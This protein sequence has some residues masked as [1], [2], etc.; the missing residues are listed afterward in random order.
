[1]VEREV[2]PTPLLYLSAFFEANRAEYYDRLQGVHVHS[3][4]AEWLAYFLN[5]V[6]RQ[7]EDAL[8]RA[9]RINALTSRWRA[10]MAGASAVALSSLRIRTARCGSCSNDWAS[11]SRQRNGQS[12]SC[13]PPGS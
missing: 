6:A 3:E 4:W 8:G 2:L 1:M 12:T 5:G 11:P 13:D 10:K 7:S 9:E